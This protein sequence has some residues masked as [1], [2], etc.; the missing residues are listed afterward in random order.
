M[1][2]KPFKILWYSLPCLI[3]TSNGAAISNKYILESLRA[4]GVGVMVLNATIADD[5][6]GM[7]EFN[8]MVAE[9]PDNDQGFYRFSLN[10]L[11][12]VVVK[13]GSSRLNEIVAKE[14]TLVWSI[15]VKIIEDFKPDLVMGFCPDLFSLS[16]RREAK[17]RGI[18]TVY[19][20]CNA[21]HDNFSFPDCDAVVTNSVAACS[22]YNR[23]NDRHVK[24]QPFGIVINQDKV[25]PPDA[26]RDPRYITMVNP[27]PYKG[28][29]L[30]IGLIRAFRKKYPHSDQRFLIVRSRGDYE[31][32]VR[33][34]HYKDGTSFLSTP[35]AND[36]LSHVD[37]AEH[38]SNI[39][40]VYQITRVMVCPSLCYEAWGMVATEAI[41]SGIPVLGTRFGGLPEAM[42]AR[43]S[44]GEDGSWNIDES[45]IGGI[46]L[47]IPRNTYDDNLCVPSDEEIAPY[48][49]ALENLMTQDWSER[50]RAAAAV[51]APERNLQRLIDII[52][53]LME[54]SRQTRTP[55]TNSFFLSD[56]YMKEKRDREN[57]VSTQPQQPAHDAAPA[58][59]AAAAA[60]P[61][62]AAA[63]GDN[64]CALGQADAAAA[65][66]GASVETS[67]TVVTGAKQENDNTVS[68][69]AAAPAA[70]AAKGSGT[71]N[72][73]AGN[74]STGKGS[75]HGQRKST[76]RKS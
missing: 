60:A 11:E 65:A 33:S 31:N 2:E 39:R 13:T 70:G 72:S 20:V 23:R 49:E 55:Y 76:A 66:A 54:R 37:L 6:S 43:V 1:L 41:M 26:P 25:L 57:G 30:F 35:E 5:D 9:L 74:K 34:L 28:I 63:A 53:P 27:T 48:L 44:T 19:A 47:D 7:K 52:V 64:S 71:R 51:N 62:A 17:A 73:K 61:S 59:S 8:S 42:G 32:T 46:V 45:T 14:Q 24:V 56:S 15:F 68:T 40:A 38:T 21:S 29:A 3:D 67:G 69:T 16:L 36:I 4:R 22:Y 10:G 50:V 18:S 58:A 12:Y 75:R